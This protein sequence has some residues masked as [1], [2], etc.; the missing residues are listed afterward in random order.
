MQQFGIY[1]LKKALYLAPVLLFISFLSFSLI[2]I[3]PGDPAEILLT[4]PN[5]AADEKAVAE[6]TEKMGLDQPLAVQYASWLGRVLHGDLGYS[7]MT[8]R[9]VFDT[10]VRAFA[11]TLKLSVLSMAVATAIAIP[12]GILA[13]VK[14][15]TIIDDLSRFGALI[16]VAIPNFWQAYIFIFVFAVF[17]KW[18]PPTG[19]GDGGDLAHMILPALVLGTGSTAVMMRMTRSSMLEEIGKDYTRTARAKGLP[20]RIVILRHVLKN[21]LIPVVTVI[22]LSVGFM[23]NGSVVVESIFGWPGIGDL[24][25]ESIYSRDYPMIQGTILFVALIFVGVNFLVDIIYAWLN[26]RITYD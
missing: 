20:E 18:L 21:A 5:G 12:A 17:L 24:M 16:G 6:F 7:Y 8:E 14:H 1:V 11:N 2:Y 10:I 13:A 25:V 9:S 23:L 4:S 26:P 19:F 15:N 22:G 3:A